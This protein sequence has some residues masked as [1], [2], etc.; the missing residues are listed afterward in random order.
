MCRG[1]YMVGSTR[2]GTTAAILLGY[3]YPCQVAN[4][5]N[6]ARCRI[7]LPLD[8]ISGMNSQEV[9]AAWRK[10]KKWAPWGYQRGPVIHF[11]WRLEGIWRRSRSSHGE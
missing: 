11:H 5:W 1:Y 7:W 4:L 8:T 9:R 10:T 2:C 6:F 3:R